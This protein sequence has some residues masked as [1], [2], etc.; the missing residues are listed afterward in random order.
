[1]LASGAVVTLKSDGTLTYDLS[2][3]DDFDSLLIGEHAMDQFAYTVS[4]GNGGQSRATVTVKVC[5]ALNTLETIHASL[6][7]SVT[8][9]LAAYEFDPQYGFINTDLQLSSGDARLNGLFEA[10]YCIDPLALAAADVNV[11]AMLYSI[12]S[13]PTGVVAKP[14]NLDKLAWLM[15]QQFETQDNGDGTGETYTGGEIQAAIWRLMTGQEYFVPG[16]GNP[17][18]TAARANAA[19]IYQDALLFGDG[20]APDEDDLLSLILVPMEDSAEETGFFQPFVVGI[21]FE[22]LT[23]D[24]ECDCLI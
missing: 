6:P 11:E 23:L 24:C 4:D 16:G 10:A 2:G 18:Q 14:E 17:P 5:G 15:N 13:V 19:E 22:E 20:F 8:F 1:M 12:A 7:E 21:P 9:G 3:V